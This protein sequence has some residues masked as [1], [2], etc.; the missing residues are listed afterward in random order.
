MGNSLEDDLRASPPISMNGF[1][2]RVS[3][4]WAL[5]IFWSEV[6]SVGSVSLRHHRWSIALYSCW[7]HQ[8][9]THGT[10]VSSNAESFQK[11]LPH[12]FFFPIAR[13][14]S[15]INDKENLVKDT[16]KYLMCNLSPWAGIIPATI[17]VDIHPCLV[18]EII[19]KKNWGVLLTTNK[20]QQ[21]FVDRFCCLSNSWWF[22]HHF[23]LYKASHKYN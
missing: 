18:I 5:D 22:L 7:L 20:I 12:D 17:K 8:G 1:D 13:K 19:K 10:R 3:Y 14:S 6:N 15:E 21:L 16:I 23:S 9:Y 2:F 4:S 11:V